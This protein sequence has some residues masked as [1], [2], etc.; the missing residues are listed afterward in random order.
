MLEYSDSLNPDIV[1]AI[2][3][4]PLTPVLADRM[5]LLVSKELDVKL[6]IEGVAVTEVVRAPSRYNLYFT[7]RF[8]IGSVESVYANTYSDELDPLY[9]LTSP[10]T[11][12]GELVKDT[13]L[14]QSVVTTI[15]LLLTSVREVPSPVEL[16]M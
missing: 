5:K 12:A 10:C 13:S 3:K 9:V 11:N 8:E 1:R 7:M 15:L 14:Q 4:L 2:T 6:P 16:S